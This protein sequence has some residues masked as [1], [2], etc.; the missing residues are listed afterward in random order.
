MSSGKAPR[1]Q[2]A[3]TPWLRGQSEALE[4]PPIGRGVGIARRQQLLAVEDRVRAGEEA[5]RLQLV[6]EIAAARGQ[7]DVRPRH[8]DPRDGDAAHELERIERR[9]V[10]ERRAGNRH[11]L[12]DRH[13]FRLRRQRRERV[14]HADAVGAR[15]AHADDAAAADL[16]AGRAHALERLEPVR[17][18]ARA[19]DLLVELGRRVQVVVVVVEAGVG[20]ALGLPRRASRPSVAHVSS[21]RALTALTIAR[22]GSSC[23]SLGPRYDAPM[24]NRVAP[25]SFARCAAARTASSGI[26]SCVSMAVSN[27]M[28]CG[29]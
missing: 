6:A 14:Q 13:A 17:I 26:R 18:G 5:Q 7:P 24:Q 29:Q 15:L 20:E 11:E 3:A 9:G 4:Q 2:L 8:Q 1:L 19:D 21:P 10:G 22:I 27:R 25:A 28:L 16:D 12:V 23:E